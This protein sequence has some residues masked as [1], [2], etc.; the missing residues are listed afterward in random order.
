M[1]KIIVEKKTWEGLLQVYNNKRIADFSTI[2]LF[3]K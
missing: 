2:Y 3:C 1:E